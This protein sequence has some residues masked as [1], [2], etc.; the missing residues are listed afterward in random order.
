MHKPEV[1]VIETQQE[2]IK[3]VDISNWE[4]EQILAKYGYSNHTTQ[5]DQVQSFDPTRDLSYQEMIELED[6]KI[7]QEQEKKYQNSMNRPKT[8]S[9]DSDQV[10]YNDVK[11]SSMDLNGQEFG[12]QVQVVSDMK[13]VR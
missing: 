3:S 12:I 8:Y 11:W 13:F 9:I 6:R 7:R 10:R 2:E 4:R 5:Y 1:R